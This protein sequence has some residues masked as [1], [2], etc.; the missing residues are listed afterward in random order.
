MASSEIIAIGS[1][2]LLGETQDTNTAYILKKLRE[3]GID[4]YRTQIIGDNV[5]RIAN[6]IRESLSRVDIV[7][8]TG[9]LG[10]TI[11]DATREAVAAA[12]DTTL[13]YDEELW[14][15]ILSYFIDRDR[16]PSE[17]NKRQA[18]LPL[19]A[20]PIH[21]AMGTAPAF[22]FEKDHKILISLPGVP[23]EMKYLTDNFVIDIL[24]N[25]YQSEETIAVRTLHT[26]GLG[27]SVVDEAVS[28]FETWSNPTLGLSAKEGITD[29]RMTAKGMSRI[30]ALVKLDDLEHKI[31]NRLGNHIY[32]VDSQ[33]LP[34]VVNQVLREN[35]ILVTVH[36]FGTEGKVASHLDADILR[37]S[38]T[39]NGA[40]V[41]NEENFA[42]AP[43]APA[44]QIL[45]KVWV[46]CA[47]DSRCTVQLTCT[48]SKTS[49]QL[50]RIFNPNLFSEQYYVF[51][52][53]ES[54]RMAVL[55]EA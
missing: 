47:E 10:P 24:R 11:D 32:G 2:L 14:R 22:Y 16:T 6:A 30:D 19:G 41:P 3:I 13:V 48:T 8:T 38:S 31:R 28:D 54:L 53:L 37:K 35:N 34:E 23:I 50:T 15:D 4:I 49:K 27:E 45:L 21:N 55:D 51:I 25:K 39:I 9:G 17:N 52:A 43:L 18:Y 1:E 29:L 26:F 20:T 7:I 46:N 36:E 40:V 33:T 44:G 42:E 12:F 5:Q